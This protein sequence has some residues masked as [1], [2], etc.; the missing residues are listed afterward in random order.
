MRLFR[1]FKVGMTPLRQKF[2]FY[3]HIQ[4]FDQPKTPKRKQCDWKLFWASFMGLKNQKFSSFN[5]S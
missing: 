4:V 1:P 2:A 3:M 5:D